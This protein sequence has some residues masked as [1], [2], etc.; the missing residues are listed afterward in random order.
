MYADNDDENGDRKEEGE[1]EEGGRTARNERQE[2]RIAVN[3]RSQNFDM[4][5][6]E[7]EKAMQTYAGVCGSEGFEGGG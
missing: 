7:N 3:R 6:E 5:G 2:I 1:V 4:L